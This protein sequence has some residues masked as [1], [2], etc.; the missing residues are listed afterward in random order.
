[1]VGLSNQFFLFLIV[2]G[3]MPS[4]EESEEENENEEYSELLTDVALE[5]MKEKGLKPPDS[6]SN[7]VVPPPNLGE[8]L[9]NLTKDALKHINKQEG[10]MSDA[11]QP[12]GTKAGPGVIVPAGAGKPV[13]KKKLKQ[14][15]T[16]TSPGQ[17][18]VQVIQ[19]VKIPPQAKPPPPKEGPQDSNNEPSVG[20]AGDEGPAER[21]ADMGANT[22]PESHKKSK[23][24]KLKQQTPAEASNAP[25]Y[26]DE[27]KSPEEDSQEYQEPDLNSNAPLNGAGQ[28]TSKG[29]GNVLLNSPSIANSQ[30]QVDKNSEAEGSISEYT[31][32]KNNHRGKLI[33]TRVK[34]PIYRHF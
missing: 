14:P 21:E 26:P 12:N 28:P 22:R 8:Q 6:I 1:M 2:V 30:E 29:Q 33:F 27:L 3:N 15:S 5:E 11:P 24:K 20:E 31:H 34:S 16:P 7:I 18:P 17:T 25:E 23:K 19:G 32:S 13:N 9:S 4:T 10:N